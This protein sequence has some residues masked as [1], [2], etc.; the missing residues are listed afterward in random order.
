MELS[1]I[2]IN[3]NN[4]DGLLRTIRSV[5]SQVFRDYEWIVIDGCSN[6]GSKEVIEQKSSLFS[7]WCSERDRGIYHAMNKGIEKASGTYVLFLNSGDCLHDSDVLESLFAEEHMSDIIYGD[8]MAIDGNEKQ[9]KTMPNQLSLARI[10]SASIAHQSSF[11][12]RTLFFNNMYDETMK[13]A[14][15]WK[16]FL[17]AFI[18]NKSF[19]HVDLIISDFYCD[20]ISSHPGSQ[21]IHHSERVKTKVELMYSQMSPL[22]G[23]ECALYMSHFYRV[24][25]SNRPIQLL[26]KTFI[27]LFDCLI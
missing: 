11:I 7:Y 10:S 22:I 20:G 8:C 13:I 14:A 26:S 19:K 27:R 15:D 23:E 5:E 3:Y 25:I 12:K 24:F 17:Y 16:W 1:I 2:T 21:K 6:D 9:V 18:N 4:K